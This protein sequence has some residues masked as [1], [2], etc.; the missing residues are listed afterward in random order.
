MNLCLPCKMEIQRRIGSAEMDCAICHEGGENI[1][2]LFLLCPFAKAV[3]LGSPFATRSDDIRTNSVKN[4]IHDAVMSSNTW[5]EN[6]QEET[7]RRFQW[8]T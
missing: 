2:H 7:L 3:W 5:D 4:S 6:I 1:D 8:H